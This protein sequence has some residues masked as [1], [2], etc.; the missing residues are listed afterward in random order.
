MTVSVCTKRFKM[1]TALLDKAIYTRRNIDSEFL[2]IAST[3]KVEVKAQA[4]KC[5][6]DPKSTDL[7]EFSNTKFLFPSL[8]PNSHQLNMFN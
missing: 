3:E 7:P 4:G 5:H 8:I 6:R 2:D 1:F